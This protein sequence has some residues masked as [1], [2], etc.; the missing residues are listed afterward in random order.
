M[1]LRAAA[2]AL[3]L[4]LAAPVAWAQA[5]VPASGDEVMHS[6]VLE[7]GDTLIGLGR[8]LL[9]D[10]ARS[11]IAGARSTTSISRSVARK[12]TWAPSASIRTLARIGMVLRRSTTDCT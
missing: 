12:E 3:A 11:T 4:V 8:R 10:P 9:V 5:A 2:A 7:A 1:R 6:H